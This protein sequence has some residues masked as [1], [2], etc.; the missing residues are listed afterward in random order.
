MKSILHLMMSALLLFAFTNTANAESVFN[1]RDSFQLAKAV[2][3]GRASTMGSGGGAEFSFPTPGSGS[4]PVICVPNCVA[5]SNSS[6]CS[7][8]ADGYYLKN[9]QCSSCPPNA[10]CSGNEIITC[11]AGY[12]LN[13]TT[14]T[15]CPAGK[16]S[17]AGASYCTDCPTGNYASGTGNTSCI[18]CSE[19]TI[20]GGAG[21]CTAC[22]SLGSCISITCVSGYMLNPAGNACV[23]EPKTCVA[24][25]TKNNPNVIVATDASSFSEALSSDKSIILLDGN[26]SGLAAVNLGSKKLVG[27]KYFSDIDLC[28]AQDTPT[29]TLASSSTLTISGGEINQLNLTFTMEDKT[30]DAI[31]GSGTIKDSTITTKLNKSVVSASGKI[32]L[33]G[34]VTLKNQLEDDDNYANTYILTTQGGSVEITGKTT[35]GGTASYGLDIGADTT[36]TVSS[37]GTLTLNMPDV[38]VGIHLNN[39]STF[40]A[41]GPVKFEQPASSSAIGYI[42]VYES[43][44]NLNANGNYLKTTYSGLMETSGMIKVNG[45]TTIECFRKGNNSCTA[46][47]ADHTYAG[48]TTKLEINAPVTVKGLTKDRDNQYPNSTGDTLLYAKGDSIKLNSTIESTTGIGKVFINMDSANFTSSGAI[49]GANYMYGYNRPMNIS[50][51]AKLKMNGVCKKATS[52]G[53]MTLE[54]ENGITTPIAPFTGGC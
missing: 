6:S 33:A 44:I 35:L 37:T 49:I 4:G 40:T 27:P 29:A 5:C 30:K 16:Y 1:L 10:T 26:I 53:T 3:L 24:L 39:G 18:S 25:A 41:N 21:Y 28:K 34:D 46:I 13:G 45:S 32:T 42:S 19:I 12:Y 51:G 43:Y 36:A 9:G 8:C 23:E 2:K 52:S 54:Y 20:S 31:S 11:R 47:N 7:K 17:S 14:C 50:A 15:A 48:T 22:T 38:F